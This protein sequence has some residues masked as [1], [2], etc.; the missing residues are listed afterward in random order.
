MVVREHLH[1]FLERWEERKGRLQHMICYRVGDEAGY[2][3]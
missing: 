1:D 3:V 2:W